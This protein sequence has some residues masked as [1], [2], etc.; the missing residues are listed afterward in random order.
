MS[1][2][3]L[4]NSEFISKIIQDADSGRCFVPLI[5]SG[6]SS[7][8]GII[9]G[10]EFTNYLAFTTYLVLSESHELESVLELA[11]T[12]GLSQMCRHR[13][14]VNYSGEKKVAI[15]RAHFVEGLVQRRKS[16]RRRRSSFRRTR[17][18]PNCCRSTCSWKSQWGPLSR[19]WVPLNTRDQIVDSA[20]RWTV[21]VA[22]SR[23]RAKV[24]FS[25]SP[26]M[27]IGTS[28]LLTSTSMARSY[29]WRSS[30]NT[31]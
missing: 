23:A 15:L 10:M 5:G 12:E 21:H 31:S 13:K 3:V 1:H 11:I 26:R 30:A 2:S 18:L 7:P 4:S 29:S 20:N 22:R 24:S 27:S 14:R 17:S 19:R 28:M 6:L 9:M 25:H 16:K 8:S